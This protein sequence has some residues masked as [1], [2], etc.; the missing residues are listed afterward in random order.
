MKFLRILFFSEKK[1]ILWNKQSLCALI[2]TR[3]LRMV[4]Q[5]T[6][7]LDLIQ[8]TLKQKTRRFPRM[9]QQCYGHL[10]CSR[11]TSR[12]FLSYVY[13]FSYRC[14]FCVWGGGLYLSLNTLTSASRQP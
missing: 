1:S 10:K 4:G 8:C 12:K 6:V 7:Y 9:S 2:V 5:S 11:R 3:L 13:Y 14:G